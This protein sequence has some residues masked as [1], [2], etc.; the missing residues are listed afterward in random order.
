MKNNEF[1]TSD[2]HFGHANIIKYSNRPF[3]DKDEMDEEMIRRWNEK[4]PQENA[5]VYFLGDI[6]F[7]RDHKKT[8]AVLNRLH[9][10]KRLVKGN[11]DKKRLNPEVAKCFEWV[12]DYYE[13]S[14]EDGV[15]VVMCH[16]PFLTWNKSH[17]DAWCLHGHSHGNLKPYHKV[18]A[19][20]L[21]EG[22]HHAAAS[23][24]LS[25]FN[26]PRRLDVGVD[27]NDFTPYSYAEVKA[28]MDKRGHVVVDHHV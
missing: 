9:G 24:V 5:I 2:T 4:I 16:Y 27:T 18:I 6:A 21:R 19:E 8:V 26:E 20:S 3:K 11:H 17:R 10:T 1:V 15:K 7:Y 28:I 12:K 23:F 22:G 25:N 13:S 14:T